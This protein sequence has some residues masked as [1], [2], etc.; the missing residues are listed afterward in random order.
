[1]A[2]DH[3]RVTWSPHS[4]DNIYLDNNAMSLRGCHA[5]WALR[6]ASCLHCTTK[7]PLR[8]SGREVP[9]DAFCIATWHPPL[10]SEIGDAQS[11]CPIVCRGHRGGTAHRTISWHVL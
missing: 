3:T 11:V 1:M 7:A 6:P 5:K 2:Y 10:D 8:M 9:V 4:Y